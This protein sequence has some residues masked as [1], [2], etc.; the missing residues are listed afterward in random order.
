MTCDINKMG[1]VLE[2]MRDYDVHAEEG[3][4]LR[5]VSFLAMKWMQ[6]W[7]A[8][9]RLSPSL[10][11]CSVAIL[12]ALSACFASIQGWRQTQEDDHTVSCRVPGRSDLS[13]FA[14]FDGHGGSSASK[15]AAENLLRIFADSLP[16][17]ALEPSVLSDHLRKAILETDN[18]LADGQ[19][20]VRFLN[21]GCTAI[22]SV[23]SRKHI[24]TANVGDSRAILVTLGGT[25][26]APKIRVD[27]LSSD[28][29][30][31]NEAEEARI[32]AADMA[33]I[34]CNGIA[35]VNGDLAVARAIGDFAFKNPD[36][37]QEKQAVTCDPEISVQER[38][39]DVA[40]ILCLACD[41]IWD[42]MSNDQVA[43]FIATQLRSHGE[44]YTTVSIC[45]SWI[46]P[47]AVGSPQRHVL[48]ALRD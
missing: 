41:G 12:S 28:Q 21:E 19:G 34:D 2:P 9:L 15:F 35:R 25:K 3:N 27:A 17:G 6:L 14:V 42:V 16:E 44:I 10:C 1:Q 22:I 48:V 24:V 31:A 37:A 23:I 26:D 30:P 8:E 45:V 36:L 32:R 47:Q 39:L 5:C 29:K 20:R 13:L 18:A 46:V 33:V 4:G 40:Q 38:A 7:T 43:Q 11:L